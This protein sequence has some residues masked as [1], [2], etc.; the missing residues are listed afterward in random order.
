MTRCCTAPWAPHNAVNTSDETTASMNLQT[1]VGTHTQHR[2][3]HSSLLPPSQHIPK[4]STYSIRR[5]PHMLWCAHGRAG[6]SA[7]AARCHPGRRRVLSHLIA[8]L[9]EV[10]RLSGAAGPP[11]CRHRLAVTLLLHLQLQSPCGTQHAL[12]LSPSLSLSH[13]SPSSVWHV[14]PPPRPARQ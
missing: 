1:H 7:H 13:S 3:T 6:H 2:Q 4:H 11:V 12:G 9:G 14:R 8:V 5:I 10:G